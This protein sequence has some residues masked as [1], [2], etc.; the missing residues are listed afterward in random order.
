[1]HA[2]PSA[3]RKLSRWPRKRGGKGKTAAWEAAGLMDWVI[4]REGYE[5]TARQDDANLAV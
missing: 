1:L 5:G 2:C 4:R 3:N